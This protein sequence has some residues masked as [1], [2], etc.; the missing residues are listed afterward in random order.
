MQSGVVVLEGLDVP[1]VVAHVA[2]GRDGGAGTGLGRD[3]RDAA[4]DGVGA[5]GDLVAARVGAA[6]RVH[7]ELNLL[8]L[9]QVEH[10][11][12]L[13]AGEPREHARR[14]ARRAQGLGR[15]LGGGDL[16]AEAGQFPAD[17][18]G[19]RL[20]AVGGAHE[21]IDPPPNDGCPS[22]RRPSHRSYA[23]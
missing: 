1:V 16:E 19:P 9:H 3:D 7:H 20:V 12:A 8:F 6:G 13:P 14:D 23:T 11:G 15:P 10:A 5:D 4:Q 22:G 2:D 17:L 21:A 18:N